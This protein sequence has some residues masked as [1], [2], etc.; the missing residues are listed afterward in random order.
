[1]AKL[2]Y[3]KYIVSELKLPAEIQ[4]RSPQWINWAPRILWMDNQVVEGAFQMTCIWYLKAEP[5]D[6]FPAHTHEYDEIIGFFGSDPQN[7]H[8]LGGEI[9]MW[10]EDEKYLLTKSSLIFAPRGMKHCP[11]V[12]R[13]VDRPIFHFTTVTGGRY[14]KKVAGE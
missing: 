6:T 9:E 13:R 12:I 14:V 1:M 3:Q 7:P 5:S 2:K 10:L 11:L 8:D 4:K